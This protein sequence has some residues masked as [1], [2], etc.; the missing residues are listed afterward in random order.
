VPDRRVRREA[1]GANAAVLVEGSVANPISQFGL[2]DRVAVV[3]GASD[4]IGRDL[5][6]GLAHAGADIVLCSRNVEKLEQAKAEIIG[7]GRKAEVCPL[8]I[9][10]LEDLRRLKSF[11]LDRFGRVDILVNAAGF[12]V[13]KPAWDV[14]EIEWDAML[15][16]GFKG[17]F[18]CCQI[19]GSIMRERK[20][21]KI[22]NLSSTFS[23]SI[24]KGR[25]V[26][27]G[28]KAG[29]SHLTEALAL[30]WG[31]H[32]IRVNALA[33]TAVMTPS[34]ST[35]LQ[36]DFLQGII[37]RIPLGRLALPDDLTNAAVYLSSPA[38]DFVTGQT[39]FVDG[40]WVAA[41]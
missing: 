20:Y 38:S 32:G 34:R 25:S 7:I 24:I 37:A 21:G 19:V 35:L 16:I 12:T 11:I 2:F 26:Y 28:I 36:D 4:G 23:R 1:R 18:F 17:L 22:I 39:L 13:T 14:D 3:T 29:I 30:E 9:S 27:G 31:E 6:I 33:P 40:G 5:A 15:D 41:S 8:D 10:K